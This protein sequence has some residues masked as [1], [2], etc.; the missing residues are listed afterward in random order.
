MTIHV[1]IETAKGVANVYDIAAADPRID[2]ITIGGQDLT[3]D[4]GIVKNP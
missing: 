2:A 3:A 4:M 1:M